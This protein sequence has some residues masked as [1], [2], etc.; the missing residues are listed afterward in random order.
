MR[1]SDWSSDV[2]SSDLVDHH[3]VA[4]MA[5]RQAVDGALDRGERII[6]RVHEQP[7]HGIDHQHAMA[8]T[9]LEHAGAAAGGA[10][11]KVQRPEQAGVVGDVVEDLALVPDVVD[12]KS[13]RLN[14]SH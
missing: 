7:A 10:G 6:E 2:C 3:G 12:R 11:G 8:A 14:S 9:A 13:T 4:V 1:I 5:E